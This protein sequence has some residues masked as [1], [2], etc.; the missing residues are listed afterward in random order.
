MALLELII[1]EGENITEKEAPYVGRNINE[2]SENGSDAAN[3]NVGA[4]AADFAN[5][6]DGSKA[7]L[8]EMIRVLPNT[9]DPESRAVRVNVSVSENAYVWPK[10]LELLK[11]VEPTKRLDNVSLED[12]LSLLEADHTADFDPKWVATKPPGVNEKS[13]VVEKRRVEEYRRDEESEWE[14][15]NRSDAGPRV[16][17]NGCDREN[18][19]LVAE[20]LLVREYSCVP[21][22]KFVLLKGGEPTN[23]PDGAK[24]ELFVMVLLGVNGERVVEC[25]AVLVNKSVREN[26]S[27]FEKSTLRLNVRLCVKTL[28]FGK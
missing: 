21:E 11:R 5:A 10:V 27:V 13:L 9:D 23:L 3:E 2:E 22:K 6:Y 17:V 28:V 26:S 14:G 18:P 15:E 12:D 20:K 4:N 7:A 8:A 19:R 24:T 25:S 1:C 16:L